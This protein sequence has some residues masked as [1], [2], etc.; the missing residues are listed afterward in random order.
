MVV[1]DEMHR[2]H[3]ITHNMTLQGKIRGRSTGVQRI[4]PAPN[5]PLKIML[6]RVPV[7]F[8]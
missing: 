7:V 3:D 5:A 4:L 8:R 6:T 1:F 2:S